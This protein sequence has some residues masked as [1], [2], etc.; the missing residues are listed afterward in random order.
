MNW[1]TRRLRTSRCSLPFSGSCDP[2]QRWEL[3]PSFRTSGGRLPRTTGAIMFR[4]SCC[5]ARRISLRTPAF[6]CGID[7]LSA[8]NVRLQVAGAAAQCQQ[9]FNALALSLCVLMFRAGPMFRLASVY[10]PLHHCWTP[11]LLYVS[12]AC[13]RE[14]SRRAA[15]RGGWGGGAHTF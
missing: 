8:C 11:L 14:Q 12:D 10:L 15:G 1:S 4:L 7:L 6:G 13:D 9:Y 5:V 3:G 2:S